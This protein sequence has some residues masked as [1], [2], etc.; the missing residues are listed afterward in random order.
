[1]NYN[2]TC[3]Y[4]RYKHNRHTTLDNQKNPQNLDLSFCINCGEVSTFRDG[5][6]S[7]V[8][9]TWTNEEAEEINTIRVAWLKQQALRSVKN[10]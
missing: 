3:P 7:K 8:S 2:T 5:V 10:G 9:R 1:M 4:C 6:L